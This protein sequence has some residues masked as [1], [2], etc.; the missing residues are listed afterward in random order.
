[1]TDATKPL[2]VVAAGGGTLRSGVHET[3]PAL[4]RRWWC[5]ALLCVATTDVLEDALDYG[6]TSQHFTLPQEV[7]GL[8]LQVL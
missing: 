5:C 4:V 8:E 2:V 3:C 1:M 6:Q 7:V